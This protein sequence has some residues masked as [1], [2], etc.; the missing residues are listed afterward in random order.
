M[1][2]LVNKTMVN[3]LNLVLLKIIKNI[4]LFQLVISIKMVLKLSKVNKENMWITLIY[5][6]NR[7]FNKRANKLIL[8]EKMIIQK[9]KTK[10]IPNIYRLP[11]INILLILKYIKEWKVLKVLV[12]FKINELII[13]SK[14]CI[15]FYII[16]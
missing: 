5:N 12:F 11:L 6:K 13:M 10:I 14:L 9:N 16:F 15:L 4:L 2:G 7:I 8:Q 1:L 3:K